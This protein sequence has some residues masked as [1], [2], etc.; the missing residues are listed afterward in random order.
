MGTPIQY[1]RQKGARQLTDKEKLIK[2]KVHSTFLFSPSFS[3]SSLLVGHALIA[4]KGIVMCHKVH[5]ASFSSSSS[6]LV[7]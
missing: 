7:R 6:F 5:H 1:Q 4:R 3:L 2:I